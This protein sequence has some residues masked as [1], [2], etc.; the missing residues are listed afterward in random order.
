L[1]MG[2]DPLKLDS[3][4]LT[5]RFWAEQNGGAAEVVHVLKEAE[6]SSRLSQ[7]FLAD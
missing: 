1:E 7:R 3:K 4:G 6:E 5:P 2:A